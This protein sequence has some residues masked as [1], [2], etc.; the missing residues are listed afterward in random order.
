MDS[1]VIR[2]SAEDALK[3]FSRQYGLYEL[4]ALIGRDGI[5][6]AGSLPDLAG[7]LDV[8]G[9]DYF[10]KSM[11]GKM[12]VADVMTSKVSGKPIFVLALP[13]RSQDGVAGII[14]GSVQMEGFSETFIDPVR[15]GQEGYAFMMA[16][17]GLLAAHPQKD[18]ILK[19]NLQDHAWGREMTELQNGLMEY[20][21]QGQDK[22][23]A[24]STDELTGWTIGVA[25]TSEDLFASIA[26]IRNMN[27]LVAAIIL[28]VVSGV[29]LLVINPIVGAVRRGVEFAESVRQG[30]LSG[31]LRLDRK[32][33]IGQ[34]A[35]A[36]DTMA[37]DLQ[38]R[39]EMAESIAGGNLDQE[40][41]LASDRDVL[42]RALREMV[43]RLNGLMLEIKGASDQ[44]ASGSSQMAASSQALS[45]GATESAS[46]LEEVMASL[47]Q[48]SAQISQNAE[49]AGSAS[50]L[51]GEARE[52]ADQGNEQMGR[53]VTAMEEIN[54]AGNKI[55]RI[56]KVIDEIAFQ[57]NLLAL[58]A[59]VEAARA[60]QHGKGFAVV[61]E[62]VRNLAGRSAQAAKETSE[63]IEE[64]VAKARNG[65]E[66]SDQT[67][68]SLKAIVGGVSK[69]ADLVDEIA[70]ASSEQAQGIGQ[71][72][73]GLG[74]IDQVTQQN[75][76]TAEE[77]A[78]AA[79]EL[80]Q[81]ARHLQNMLGG[82][83]VREQGR[84]LG[85]VS[86]A[87]PEPEEAGCPALPQGKPGTG[88]SA[89]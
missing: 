35:R 60:G 84:E 11:A 26:E 47:N 31:R 69:V 17:S 6:V 51:T 73:T 22:I 54:G 71:V 41:V 21:F 55:S 83:V 76:A 36:L 1:Q 61:A 49:N 3:K 75:T 19:T 9:R 65:S 27:I 58:N 29:V 14:L 20:S 18:L 5:C 28:A 34:L 10:Q 64:A 23:M 77:S 68:T 80:S 72:N 50:S 43:D 38:A 46:S 2:G 44:I 40:V 63:L 53:L 74:Q 82:F 66:I 89:A 62:E 4:V 16:R 85:A 57:T 30:D 25:A 67:V 7:T 78:A 45:Q 24:F 88:W 59:A 39:A 79:E 32:D 87:L 48:M 86:Y 37:D 15:V 42:G 70:V 8:S 33:E 81:Q 12:V 13:V 56:I 52:L